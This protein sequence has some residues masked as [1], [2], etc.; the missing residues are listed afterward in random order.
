MAAEEG[1]WVV[2]KL[3]G[4]GL[5]RFGFRLWD[6]GFLV[7]LKVQWFRVSDS[8]KTCD[9]TDGTWFRPFI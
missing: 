2:R 1:L 9:G 4:S 6:L 5:R 8:Q 3:Q 7:G